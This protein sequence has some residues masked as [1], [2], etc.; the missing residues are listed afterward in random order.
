M[1]DYPDDYE[2]FRFRDHRL[3]GGAHQA[4]APHR[5]GYL[6][7]YEAVKTLPVDELHN[8]THVAVAKKL[9]ASPGFSDLTLG[10]IQVYVRR[11][12]NGT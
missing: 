7:V 3:V 9:K 8:A 10:T 6:R 5:D 11:C 2:S 12:R 1:S 4:P